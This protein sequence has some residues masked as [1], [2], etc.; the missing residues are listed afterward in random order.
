MRRLKVGNRREAVD[1][2]HGH[3]AAARVVEFGI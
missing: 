2:V 1:A 3:A